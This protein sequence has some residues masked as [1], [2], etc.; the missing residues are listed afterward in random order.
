MAK[1]N[2]SCNDNGGK[3]QYFTVTAANKT[4]AINKGLEK[5]RKN[6]KGDIGFNWNCS[7]KQA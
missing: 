1:W 7:L 3:H 2:F 6:A 4:E 5:A